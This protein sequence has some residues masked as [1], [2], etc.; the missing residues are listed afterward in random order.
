[1]SDALRREVSPLGI[2]VLVVEPGAFRTDFSGRSLQQ[3]GTVI[4]DYND[5]AGRRRK[6][7]D[8]THGRQPGDPA[9]GAQAIIMGAESDNPTFRL[10]LGSD[11]IQYVRAEL[12]AQVQELEAWEAVHAQ[13][14][15]LC[16]YTEHP[17][18]AR[19][20]SR[21]SA[22]RTGPARGGTCRSR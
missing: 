7:N 1:M 4:A 22:G 10:L 9:R 3:S 19:E 17:T 2:K 15:T 21:S 18:T 8:T 12:A 16:Q 6:E 20:N 11:A 13:G 5:T 14:G